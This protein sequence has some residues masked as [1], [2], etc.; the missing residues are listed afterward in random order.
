MKL[1]D[2]IKNKMKLFAQ[3][4]Y[5]SQFETIMTNMANSIQL[6]AKKPKKKMLF[7]Y[8][9]KRNKSYWNEIIKAILKSGKK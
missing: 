9:T 3:P 8:Q 5:I 6:P 7:N 4:K 1:S 2:S